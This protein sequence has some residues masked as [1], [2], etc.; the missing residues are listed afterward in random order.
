MKDQGQYVNGTPDLWEELKRTPEILASVEQ[1]D[2]SNA[3]FTPDEQAEIGHR[4]D[5][6]KH[7]VRNQ[8]EP[9]DEQMSA[10]EQTLD[11]V[12]E[13]STRVGRKDWAM[14][15]N[16]ALLSLIVNDLVPAQVIQSVFST[17]ITGIGHIF[18]LGGPLPIITP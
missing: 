4:V 6:I 12:K 13:A 11:E 2:T 10:I 3:P 9:T 14:M 15:A 8:F 17:L 5:E 16:G 7:L 18:G 1:G